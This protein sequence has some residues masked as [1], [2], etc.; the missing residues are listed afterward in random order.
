MRKT[1]IP[2][3]GSHA[4]LGPRVARGCPGPWAP[5]PRPGPWPS[6]GLTKRASDAAHA[7]RD[8][9]GEWTSGP[10]NGGGPWGRGPALRAEGPKPLASAR[11]RRQAKLL[12]GPQLSRR[13]PRIECLDDLEP[14]P[15]V[16]RDAG[17]VVAGTDNVDPA[18][19]R[20]RA[21]LEQGVPGGTG[22]GGRRRSSWGLRARR[23]VRRLRGGACCGSRCRGDRDRS[24]RCGVVAGRHGPCPRS[25]SR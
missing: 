5:R 17:H 23:G 25:P 7:R 4:G 20:V 19:G 14:N 6:A 13:D 11:G 21:R 12:A 1:Q 15:E 10:T 9:P 3:A 18:G 24:D 8:G 22:T 2:S 16:V